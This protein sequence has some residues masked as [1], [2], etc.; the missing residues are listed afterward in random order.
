MSVKIKVGFG[1]DVHPLEEGKALWLGG[2]Q[3]PHTKGCVGHR[4]RCFN[5]RHL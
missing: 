1:F 5:T 4:C 3:I 2:V